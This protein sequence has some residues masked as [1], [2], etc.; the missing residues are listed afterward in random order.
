MNKHLLLPDHLYV[1]MLSSVCSHWQLVRYVGLVSCLKL[2]TTTLY[3][4]VSVL[5]MKVSVVKLQ[6]V[7]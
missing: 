3:L 6:S 5:H 2:Q 7:L 4:T 1:L